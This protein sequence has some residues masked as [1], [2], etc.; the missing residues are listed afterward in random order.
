MRPGL[1][2]NPIFHSLFAS[3]RFG[4][5]QQEGGGGV[6]EGRAN[7]ELLEKYATTLN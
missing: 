6:L 5:F 2:Q 1:D 4:P 7:L 3:Q